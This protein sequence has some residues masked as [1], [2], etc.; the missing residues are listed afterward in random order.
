MQKVIMNKVWKGG[1]A[2][3]QAGN[4]QTIILFLQEIVEKYVNMR[5]KCNCVF[6]DC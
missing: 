2:L 1:T 3:C 4:A 5:K 6:V